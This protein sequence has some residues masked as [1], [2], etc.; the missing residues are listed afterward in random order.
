MELRGILTANATE[1]FSDPTYTHI[2][3]G[4]SY[5][6]TDLG[7]RGIFGGTIFALNAER[8]TTF[9]SIEANIG[10][11][12]SES[13]R[14]F[15]GLRAMQIDDDLVLDIDGAPSGIGA[16]TSNFTNEVSNRLIG[17]QIGLELQADNLSTTS[18][19]VTLTGKLGYLKSGAAASFSTV[20]TG[21]LASPV[22]AGTTSEDRWTAMA[23]FGVDGTWHV[24]DAMSIEFG[25]NLI[26][27]D[28]LATSTKTLGNITIATGTGTLGF[29]S[30]LYHGGTVKAVWRF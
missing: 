26:Y 8:E 7:G 15:V 27:I 28:K 29:E 3:G 20:G 14:L 5:G 30:A 12:Q 22:I 4:V 21:A 17:P 2:N 19:D 25:Y 11:S 24:S 18:F 10:S 9:A 16:A 6:G 1:F 23:E 13:A